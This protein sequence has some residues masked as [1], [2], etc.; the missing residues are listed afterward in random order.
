MK[1]KVVIISVSLLVILVIV[2][3]VIFCLKNKNE[4]VETIQHLDTDIL[5]PDVLQEDLEYNLSTTEET[6][7]NVIFSIV[8]KQKDYH[9]Y[10]AIL[11]MDEE[12]NIEDVKDEDYCLYE[13]EITIERNSYIFLKYKDGDKYS[14]NPYKIEIKNIIASTVE[15]ETVTEEE[16]KEAQVDKEEQ[17]ENKSTYYIKVNYGANVVTVYT[18]DDNGEYTIPVKAM[19]CSCGI[20]TPTSGVY[21]TSNKY[22]WRKLVG[23]VYGQYATRIVGSILFH[24]VPYTTNKKDALEYWEYDKLGTKASAGCV[25]LT[26]ADSKWIYSNCASG[27]MVEFYSSSNPGPLG[28]PSSQKIS[29]YINLRDWDPTDSD[30]NNP[31]RYTTPIEEPE[32]QPEQNTDDSNNNNQNSGE[33]TNNNQENQGT[34][35]NPGESEDTSS[36]SKEDSTDDTQTDSDK[37]TDSDEKPSTKPDD[38]QS[39]DS[40]DDTQAGGTEE[41]ED[42]DKETE[43]TVNN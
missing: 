36:D 32:E 14:S 2:G 17:K 30:S 15:E 18:K 4:S 37:V 33:N 29:K 7:E 21:K 8:S 23:G 38:N 43:Q 26:V 42:T 20:A 41:K 24:S 1:K 9:I 16:L 22:V 40:K 34:Q 28:K 3:I 10:Y 39:S 6:T 35:T 31:W 5:L 25:R 12:G 11:E 19:V 27:T 13:K